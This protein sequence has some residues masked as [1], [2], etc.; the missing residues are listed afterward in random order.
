V[1]HDVAARNE[2]IEALLQSGGKGAN[3]PGEQ[4]LFQLYQEARADRELAEQKVREVRGAL[5]QCAAL[6][7]Q[8]RGAERAHMDALFQLSRAFDASEEKATAHLA[9]FD[10]A[11]HEEL[12]DEPVVLELGSPE[13]APT[14]EVVGAQRAG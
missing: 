1:D 14:P 12:T 3:R 11:A 4:E 7:E 6:C 2:Y 5:E 13:L 10:A 8:T 9:D